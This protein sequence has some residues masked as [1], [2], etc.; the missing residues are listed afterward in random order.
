[1]VR[2]DNRFQ[3]QMV[4]KN[5]EPPVGAAL[6]GLSALRRSRSLALFFLASVLIVIPLGCVEVP[7]VVDYPN[8]LA[9][10]YVLA[11]LGSDPWLSRIYAAH[12]AVIPNLGIDLLVPWTLSFLP[13]HLAGRLVLALTLLLPVI[14][15][16]AYS[17]A[18]F[19]GRSLWPFGAFL[20]SYNLA[21][22]LGFENLLLSYGAALLGAAAFCTTMRTRFLLS[23]AIGFVATI[24][25]F[26]IHLSGCILLVGIIFLHEIRYA[27]EQVPDWRRVTRVAVTQLC[28]FAGILVVPVL[29]YLASPLSRV[30]SHDVWL[31][32]ADKADFALSPVLNY[33]PALDFATAACLIAAI[34]LCLAYGRPRFSPA[35]AILFLLLAL[36]Y[37]WLPSVTKGTTYLDVRIAVALG[38]LG[39]CVFVPRA[40]PRPLGVAI[41]VVFV[42]LFCLRTAA[43]A[44]VW[45][46]HRPDLAE[47]RETI[48]AIAPGSRV[49]VVTA[50]GPGARGFMVGGDPA[51]Q[52]QAPR[53]RYLSV[54]G[55]PTY[56]NMAALVTIE[57][58]AFF[59]FLF[60]APDKQ[61]LAVLPPYKEISVPMGEVPRYQ[62]LGFDQIS[63][64]ALRTFP[65][66]AHWRATFDY[67]L[68]LN[69]GIAGDLQYLLPDKLIFVR[70]TPFAA[71]FRIRKSAGP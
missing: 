54:I 20:V 26:F 30:A 24:L 28:G 43:V 58:Q 15:T 67:V 11:H 4:G 71:L 47:L 14:G 70:Q 16:I 44:M 10:L 46:G 56:F 21:F 6:I 69:A 64:A 29:L 55:Y 50:Q 63:T 17:R 22:L 60:S 35:A 61:P 23:H 25:V 41:A 8:H 5:S 68:I 13:L 65:Y 40:L 52:P 53:S 42:A 2:A 9:R 62:G 1:M 34:A 18:V 7:P 32:A 36:A 45:Y 19:G 3:K 51:L 39:F 48:G 49:L 37:P 33:Y 38:F 57:H 31:S 66:V 27:L 59:P 12:W